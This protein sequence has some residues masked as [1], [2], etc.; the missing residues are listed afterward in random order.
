MAPGCAARSFKL[1]DTVDEAV[2]RS[3][4]VETVIVVKRTGHDIKMEQGRDYWYHDL[5]ALPIASPKPI[6]K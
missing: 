3:P 5:M 2:Q 6:P 1:K 4:V